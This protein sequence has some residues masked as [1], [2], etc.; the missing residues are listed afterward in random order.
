MCL[1]NLQ[2]IEDTDEI[3]AECAE[4]E[5]PVAGDRDREAG[6]SADEGRPQAYSTFAPEIFTARPRLS[7]SFF[8]YAANSAGELP[9]TS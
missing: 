1:P 2:V 8:M 5:R 6:R 3:G 7:K 4:I 9:T